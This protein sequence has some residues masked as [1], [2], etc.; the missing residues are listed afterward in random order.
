MRA[1]REKA[2][3]LLGRRCVTFVGAAPH[4]VLWRARP[5]AGGLLEGPVS[6]GNSQATWTACSKP[7]IH[8]MP[9]MTTLIHTPH[10]AL[11]Q[12]PPSASSRDQ[13]E[14]VIPVYNEQRVL[15][16]SV[17]TLH[18][19]L[20][21][22]FA[23]SVPHHDRRQRQHRRTLQVAERLS[24]GSSR[25]SPSCTSSAR[26]AAGRCAR[27]GPAAEPT[28]SPTWTSTCRP[29]L[30]RSTSCCSPLLAG[31]G[32]VAIG[33]R[34][35]SGA[36]VTRGIKREVISRSYNLLL[37]VLLGVGF[38]DAQCGFKAARREVVEQ[39]LADVEDEAWFFDTEL[40]YAA[41][42]AKFAIH[43]VPVRW[44][45]D[46]DSRVDII[47]TAREDLRGVMRLRRARRRTRQPERAPSLDR[48]RHAR[49]AVAARSR[50]MTG[51]AA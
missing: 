41:Q 7:R 3:S 30:A 32:D 11:Q 16:R 45:D 5:R 47:A 15:D 9:G 13:V 10:A 2:E 1:A 38:S 25:R 46:P 29:I 43:E 49:P 8:S 20:R 44:I 48:R 40:L 28:S 14:I 27:P 12:A 37:R 50:R 24:H 21:R 42:R 36:Q 17:R 39:L 31:R 26:V 6:S 35:T 34:L 18:E 33:S 22:R 51:H 4:H 23:F 19:Y